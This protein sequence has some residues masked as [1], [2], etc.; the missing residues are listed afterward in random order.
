M[1]CRLRRLLGATV[2]ALVL[3]S[4]SSG[5]D[6]WTVG[7]TS[8]DQPIDAMVIAGASP[9]AP[10]VLLLAGLQGKDAGTDIVTR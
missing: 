5:A 8:S 3:V 10:T 1:I 2:L 4:Q 6:H 7:L 9:S